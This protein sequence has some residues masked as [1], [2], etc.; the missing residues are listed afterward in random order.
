MANK[1]SKVQISEAKTS[2]VIVTFNALD[3]V[4]KCLE[5]VLK[6]TSQHHEIIIVD[7][8][9]EDPTREYLNKFD[10]LP[11]FKLMFNKENRLW[12]P[13]NNQGIKMASADSEFILLLNSDVEVF[14]PVWLQALQEPMKRWDRV[15]ITGTQYNFDPVWPTLG[16]IDGCC[17]MFRKELLK[18]IGPLN[19]NYPWNGA[20]SIFTYKA[21]KH[22][23]Y[24]YHVDD[25]SLLVHYGKRSRY[26]NNFQLRNQKVRKFEVMDEVGLKGRYAIVPFI[27]YKMNLLKINRYIESLIEE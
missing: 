24:Y 18:E 16:A 13:A 27:K 23:W 25:P 5:S 19:E 10:P 1:L 11:N 7:N 26:S 21:W 22:G 2:I 3:Y 12:S 17:F 9:S 14:K 20:G 8:A 4:K 15:A 6:N